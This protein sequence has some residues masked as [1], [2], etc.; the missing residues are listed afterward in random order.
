MD[1]G[2]KKGFEIFLHEKGQLWPGLDMERIGQTKPVDLPARTEV[3]GTFTAVSRHALD[4]P[5]APCTTDPNYSFTQC[6]R[7]R[8]IKF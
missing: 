7:N 1:Q 2:Y 8:V 4:R 6:M 3:W 5:S